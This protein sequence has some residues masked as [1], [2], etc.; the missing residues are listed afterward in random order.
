MAKRNETE[1]I[2]MAGFLFRDEEEAKQAKK[3]RDGIKFVRSQIDMK[4]PEKV[5]QTYK[6]L[7]EQGYFQTVVGYCYLKELQEYLVTLPSIASEDIPSIPVKSRDVEEMI[8]KERAKGREQQKQLEAKIKNIKKEQKTRGR[9]SKMKFSLVFNVILLLCVLGMFLVSMTS[10]HP[11]I[12]NYESRIL[13][14][15][16]EWDQELSEREQAVK[17]K[18]FELGIYGND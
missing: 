4:Q 14:R 9:D 7:I 12:I 13:D 2:E 5:L 3:E 18:E 8:R 15:Y 17:E 1:W 10:E 6:K 11:T 16:S